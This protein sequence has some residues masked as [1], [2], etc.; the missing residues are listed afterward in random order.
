MTSLNHD[1]RSDARKILHAYKQRQK[2]SKP[3]QNLNFT[4]DNA[5]KFGLDPIGRPDPR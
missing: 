1:R 3:A 4:N 2:P 5:G